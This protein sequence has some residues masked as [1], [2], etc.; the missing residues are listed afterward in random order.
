MKYRVTFAAPPGVSL[1]VAQALVAGQELEAD[2]YTVV[3][4][5]VIFWGV[6]RSSIIEY[7]AGVWRSVA[8][9]GAFTEATKAPPPERPPRENP[10]R[11]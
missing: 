2:E 3:D 10:Q 4:G 1:A 9:V 5:R 6:D 7:A 11:R 8:A